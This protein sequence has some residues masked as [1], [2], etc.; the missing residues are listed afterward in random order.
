MNSEK[1]I[2]IGSGPA[3]LTAGMYS[4]R[5]QLQP[6]IFEGTTPGG[7]LM[8]TTYVDNWPS[9]PHILGPELMM[10][11][12]QQTEE[13]GARFATRSITRV[14]FSQNTFVLWDNKNTEYHAHSVIITTGATPKRLGCAG[15]DAYW[16]KGV[17]T[18]AVCD[19]AFYKDQPVVIVGGG[20]TAMENASFMTNFTNDITII[21]ILDTLTASKAM[22]ERVLNNPSIK[23]RY[24]SIVDVIEGDGTHVTGITLT[25]KTT[26]ERSYISTAA[27]FIAIGSTPNTAPFKEY[28]ELDKYGYVVLKQFTQ[29][30]L[31]G[32]FAA[33][34]V[35]DY[36]YRQAIASAGTGCMAALDAERFLK[37]HGR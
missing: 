19:G 34:D 6:L 14:D 26:G 1:I 36:R 21:H 18:C 23:I 27:V 12:K 29:T 8:G 7:Q 35:A 15:E 3:G 10:R 16:G 25:N 9:I 2:I 33:G 37:E 30:S 24:T 20:D 17:T 13:L 4:A 31:P 32:V 22:Q 5:A 28:I 11:M